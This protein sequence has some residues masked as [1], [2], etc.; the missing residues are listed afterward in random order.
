[1]E[2]Y[3]CIINRMRVAGLGLKKHI[4]DNKA[5][6]TFKELIRENGLEYKFVPP[7]NHSRNQAERAIQ[8]IKAHFIAILAGF[9]DKFPLS[10]WCP[11]LEPTELTL[12]LLRQSKVAPK[13][14]AFAHVHGPHDYMKKPFAPLGMCNTG[15]RQAQQPQNLGCKSRR[16]FQPR[17]LNGTP[18]LLPRLHNKN[19]INKGQ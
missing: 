19:T 14:S 15:P 13:I 8:T 18:P 10:L 1:M 12:S 4:L 2:V 7:Q 16:R 11:L 6:K 5:S 3:Q 9:D 17:Y